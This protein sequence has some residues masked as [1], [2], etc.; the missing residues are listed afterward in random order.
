MK[1]IVWMLTLLALLALC[2]AGCGSNDA[3]VAE[4]GAAPR[5]S[6]EAAAYI[7]QTRARSEALRSSLENDAL[8]QTEMN[9]TSQ[10]LRE[11]W[12]GAMARLLEE[13]ARILPEAELA[14]LTADQFVWEAESQSAVD[15]ASQPYTGGSMYALIVNTE[16]ARLTEERVNALLELLK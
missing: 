4:D 3:P 2:L 14:Q 5:L 6:T 10:E 16:A 13:A 15:A 1:K 7:E 9:V 8:T 12:E 11:L